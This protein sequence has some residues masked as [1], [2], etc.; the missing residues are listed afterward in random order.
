MAEEQP[1]DML[2]KQAMRRPELA[3]SELRVALGSELAAQIDWSTMRLVAEA[4]G[5]PLAAQQRAPDPLFVAKRV[6]GAHEP[7]GDER[8]EDD[9]AEDDRDEVL[10]H[11]LFEHQSSISPIMPLRLLQYMVD[12]WSRWEKENRARP[13]RRPP[14]PPILPVVLSHD[15]R[16]WRGPKRLLELCRLPPEDEVMFGRFVPAFD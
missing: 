10:I 13:G 8:A 12:A 16:G 4:P 1:R 6:R 7:A 11:L 15:P 3:A 2:V 5:E 14:L 9:R